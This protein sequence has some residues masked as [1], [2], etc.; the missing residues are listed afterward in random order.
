[1]IRPSSHDIPLLFST[2]II[3]LFCYGFVSVILA[4]YLAAAGFTEGQIGL[5]FTFTLAGDA[6]HYPVADH[7]G[8][9]I[10]QKTHIDPGGPIDGRSRHRLRS[11]TKHFPIDLRGSGGSYQSERE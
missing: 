10:W 7:I 8:R 1:M 4:L 5:L 2:R 11:H 6:V 9:P 3:R